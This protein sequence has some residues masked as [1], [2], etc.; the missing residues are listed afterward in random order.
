MFCVSC[1]QRIPDGAVRCALCGAATAASGGPSATAA[2]RARLQALITAG[3]HDALK[4]L[5]VLRKSPLAGV[6]QSFAMLDPNRALIVGGIFCWLFVLLGSLAAMRGVGM[7]ELGIAIDL[8]N[9]SLTESFASLTRGS[10]IAKAFLEGLGLAGALIVT[11]A[12]ARIVFRGGGQFAGDVY[13]A[14]ASLLPLMVPFLVGLILG[15]AIGSPGYDGAGRTSFT[16]LAWK[17]AALKL[18]TVLAFSYTTLMLYTG[19]SKI[20]GVPEAKTALATAI[21]LALSLL[22]LSLIARNLL[23]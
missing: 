21:V 17:D 18:S 19:F 2:R 15:P 6:G 23:Q 8:G 9:V 20:T 13:I 10:F 4:V 22:A 5:T 12:L 3:A 7:I 16:M 11:C 1:G 14:G